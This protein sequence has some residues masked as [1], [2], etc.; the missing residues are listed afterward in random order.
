MAVLIASEANRCGFWLWSQA[1]TVHHVSTLP[2][3]DVTITGNGLT[4]WM[5]K[6]Y[7][8]GPNMCHEYTMPYARAIL[9]ALIPLSNGAR[10]QAEHILRGEP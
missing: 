6:Q 4:I 3:I 5:W 7:G 8:N 1:M 10:E 2:T 9:A